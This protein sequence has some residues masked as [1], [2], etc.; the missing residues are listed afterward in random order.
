MSE[1]DELKQKNKELVKI[2]TQL[3]KQAKHYLEQMTKENLINQLGYDLQNIIFI[4]FENKIK[5]LAADDE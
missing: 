3:L 2:A 5:Q 1:I 4:E